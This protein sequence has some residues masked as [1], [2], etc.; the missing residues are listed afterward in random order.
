MEDY[1]QKFVLLIPPILLAL[2]VHECAHAY[3]AARL[4]DDTAR[5]MGRITLNPLKHLDPVGTLALFLTGMFGWARPVP[6]NPYNFKDPSKAMMWVSLA[7]PLSNLTLAALFAFFL[8]GFV[9]SGVT[10]ISPEASPVAGPLLMMVQTSIVLNTGLAIFNLLP[11][12]PL[13]GSRV[14][15]NILPPDKA[16]T[17][18]KIEPYGFI[19]I[20]LLMFTGVISRI[21][22]PLI[23]LTVG[24]L[25]MVI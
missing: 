8:K 1:I 20:M 6:V 2:T 9:L 4:G 25:T 11:I 3:V 12:P 21:I 16:Y 22:S 17:F 18:S 10:F 15:L 5:L 14:L 24:L 19:I 13:D 23:M 7:G